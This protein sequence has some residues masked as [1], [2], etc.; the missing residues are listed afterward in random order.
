MG[1]RGPKPRA[2]AGE[3]T[4]LGAVRVSAAELEAYRAAAAAEHL[5]VSEWVRAAL[6]AAAAAKE[7]T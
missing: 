1:L 4:S 5:S 3:M 2:G 7:P 6:A